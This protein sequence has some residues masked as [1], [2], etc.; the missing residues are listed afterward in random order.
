MTV[1]AHEV[2]DSPIKAEGLIFIFA[3]WT[4]LAC[5]F[6]QIYC[7]ETKGLTDLEKKKCF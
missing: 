5:I 1:M 2:I 7:K 4:F 3:F 6:M